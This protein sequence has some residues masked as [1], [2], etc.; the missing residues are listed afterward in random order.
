MKQW[1]L[2]NNSLVQLPGGKKVTFLKMDGMYAQW[3]VD[4]KV[5]IGNFAAFEKTDFGYK[6]VEKK[7]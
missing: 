2:P 1:E 6:V 4:G 7:E 3:D 5:K